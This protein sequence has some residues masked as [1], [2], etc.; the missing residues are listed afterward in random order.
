M[1]DNTCASKTHLVDE[2]FGNTPPIRHVIDLLN[3]F[4]HVTILT[5]EVFYK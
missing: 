3:I 2:A 4:I 1:T 5:T